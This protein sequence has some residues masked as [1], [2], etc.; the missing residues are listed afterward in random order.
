[1]TRVT[2]NKLLETQ[3]W[4]KKEKGKEEEKEKGKNSE[5]TVKNREYAPDDT[6]WFSHVLAL[7]ALEEGSPPEETRTIRFHRRYVLHFRFKCYHQSEGK[8]INF[9]VQYPF[10]KSISSSSSSSCSR[11]ILFLNFFHFI[12][13]YLNI[14]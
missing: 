2:V 6:D 12:Y 8:R 7:S 4:T 5:K 13:L 3:K 14:L 10:Q 11:S 1:M 9:D